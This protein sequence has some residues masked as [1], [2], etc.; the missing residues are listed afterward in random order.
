MPRAARPGTKPKDPGLPAPTTTPSLG[1][2]LI[3]VPGDLEITYF[4]RFKDSPLK[5]SP[6]AANDAKK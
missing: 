1:K 2:Y 4:S 6:G 3:D 5:K